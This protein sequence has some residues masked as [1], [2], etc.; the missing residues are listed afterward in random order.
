MYGIDELQY[1][2]EAEMFDLIH[3][4][5]T[6]IITSPVFTG[7]RILGAILQGTLDRE[8]DGMGNP[9][10]PVGKKGILPILKID[11]GLQEAFR[12]CATDAGHLRSDA[13]PRARGRHQCSGQI[14]WRGEDLLKTGLLNGL[15]ALGGVGADGVDPDQCANRGLR[16]GCQRPDGDQPGPV[17]RGRS[18]RVLRVDDH[19]IGAGRGGR[20]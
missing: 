16:G 17:L 15:G 6:R 18:D 2:S 9:G 12:R 4:A 3:A 19:H 11:Q 8:I 13:D 10:I 7:D 14:R 1:S 20:E 5:R